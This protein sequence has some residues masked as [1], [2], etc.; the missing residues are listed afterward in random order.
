MGAEDGDV[1]SMDFIIVA[2]M[3]G[4]VI[5]LI[6]AGWHNPVPSLPREGRFTLS[7]VWYIG[8]YTANFSSISLKAGKQQRHFLRVKY[9]FYCASLICMFLALTRVQLVRFPVSHSLFI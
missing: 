5:D 6:K 9:I 7:L 8:R 1:C 4:D 3:T 2:G